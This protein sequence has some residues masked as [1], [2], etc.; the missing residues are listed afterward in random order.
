MD[1]RGASPYSPTTK[2][3]TSMDKN[4]SGAST[5]DGFSPAIIQGEKAVN[6]EGE[7]DKSVPSI[8]SLKQFLPKGLLWLI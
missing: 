6:P 3:H 4:F 1:W 2:N 8:I 7:R 5:K